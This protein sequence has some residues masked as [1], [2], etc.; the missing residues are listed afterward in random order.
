MTCGIKTDHTLWC[1]GKD[2]PPDAT[3]HLAPTQ[4]GTDNTWASLSM[5]GTANTVYN[6]GAT[7]CAIKLDGAL[8]CW[9]LWLGDG[10]MNTSPTPVQ[11]GTETD[12]RMVATGGEIC[13]I[14]TGGTLWCWG[15]TSLLGD[16]SPA[17]YDPIQFGTPA[18]RPTQIGS[19]TDWS[20][21]MTSGS[22]STQSC[23]LKTDGSLWCWGTHAAPI[24]NVEPMPMPIN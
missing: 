16:G 1:W 24:P 14:K 10:T 18:T 8:W 19:D 17:S 11:V 23:A 7:V 21:V 3:Q 4:V 12:W 22:N 6:T 15:N 9:G 5:S 20:K 13:A 2:Q